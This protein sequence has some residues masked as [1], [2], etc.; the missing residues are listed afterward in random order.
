MGSKKLPLFQNLYVMAWYFFSPL[1]LVLLRFWRGQYF[2]GM[3]LQSLVLHKFTNICRD[4]NVDT[5]LP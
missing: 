4:N 5:C 1:E 2:F 3:I